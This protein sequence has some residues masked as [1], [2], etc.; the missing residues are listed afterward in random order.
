MTRARDLML[1]QSCTPPRPSIF[2][3]AARAL[4]SRHM[5]LRLQ[6]TIRMSSRRKGTE[7]FPRPALPCGVHKRRIM[8]RMPQGAHVV[9]IAHVVALLY[10]LAPILSLRFALPIVIAGRIHAA[11]KMN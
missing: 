2:I 6:L 9:A 5:S 4:T 3:F 11:G 7:L 8:Q 1:Q 10:H